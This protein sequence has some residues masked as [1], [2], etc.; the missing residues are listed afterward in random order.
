MDTKNIGLEGV[1]F[2]QSLSFSVEYFKQNRKDILTKKMASIPSYT[3]LTL[4]DQN[5]GEVT[6][7]GFEFVVNYNQK[8]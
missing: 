8:V 4:P 6:N 5:I 3:G 2:N 7:Q 1:F